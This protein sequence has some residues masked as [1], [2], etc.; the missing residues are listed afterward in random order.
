MSRAGISSSLID[1]FKEEDSVA[2]LENKVALI[3]G[4]SSGIGYA[5]AK[6]FLAEGAKVVIT[7]RRK[8]HLDRA[9]QELGPDSF[10]VQADVT[11]LTELD[12]LYVTIREKFKHLDIVVANA[13]G[14]ALEALGEISEA[15]FDQTF[16]TNVKGVVFTVQK[17]LP[18]LR[19]G[20]SIILI[21]STTSAMGTPAFSI[22]S[23]MKAAVRNLVRSWV[24]DLKGRDIRVNVL[25]PGT[26]LTPALLSI[27]GE[28]NQDAVLAGFKAQVPMGRIADPSEI[29]N[30]ACF[31]ASDAASYV[32][33]AE[34][35]ADGGLAQ[36]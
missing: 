27:G 33:G 35:F 3:T 36:V 1:Q 20:A 4:G 21:G 17:S 26:T 32:H 34:F 15:N 28:N 11:K 2:Q 30:V 8:D 13:G 31:L 5:I 14:G 9:V 19:K 16:N 29:A 23:A 18:L 25:S 22:Y 7:G 6:K 24:L 10:G 12:Q